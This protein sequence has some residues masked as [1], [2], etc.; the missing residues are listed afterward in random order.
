MI[1]MLLLNG[2]RTGPAAEVAA[3]DHERNHCYGHD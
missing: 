3:D 2:G 1:A